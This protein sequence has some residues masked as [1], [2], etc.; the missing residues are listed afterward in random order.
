MIDTRRE[1]NPPNITKLSGRKYICEGCARDFGKAIGMVENDVYFEL[2]HMAQDRQDEV[3]RLRAELETARAS[4]TRVVAVDDLET[5]ISKLKP[6]PAPL[7]AVGIK[8]GGGSDLGKI[9]NA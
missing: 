2:Q 5:F 8:P 1:F 3:E 7:D 6:A 4:Q 9:A